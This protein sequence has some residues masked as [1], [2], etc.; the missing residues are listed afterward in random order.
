MINVGRPSKKL[1]PIISK[2]EKKY[3]SPIILLRASK[4]T[5]EQHFYFKQTI[6]PPWHFKLVQKLFFSVLIS[7]VNTVTEKY[8]QLS[9]I[10]TIDDILPLYSRIITSKKC[11]TWF[12]SWHGTKFRGICTLYPPHEFLPYPVTRCHA[13]LHFAV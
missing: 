10:V 2:H 7:L 11:T 5:E 9:T 3:L 6:L 4:I 1:L 8:Y 12:K 13:M